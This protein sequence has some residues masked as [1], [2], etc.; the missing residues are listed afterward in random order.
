MVAQ[1]CPTLCN[2]MDYSL[3][4][5]SVHGTFQTRYWSGLPFPSPGDLSHPAIE[6]RSPALPAGSLPSEP[7]GKPSS[8]L[9]WMINNMV[10]L[11]ELSSY[12]I[13]YVPPSP[14]GS[15]PGWER[16]PGEGN[17]NPVQYSCLE[18]PWAE[19]P[20]RLQSMGSQN[21]GHD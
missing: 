20:G 16:S 19:E 14:V 15:V 6:P 17:G 10:A 9:G 18:I 8:I 21:A 2:P 7:P 3:Q 11:T 5:S 1:S 12:S 4:G 13:K